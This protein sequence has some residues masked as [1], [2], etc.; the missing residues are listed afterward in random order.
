MIF[1]SD[2]FRHFKPD[3]V[4]DELITRV[5][6]AAIRASS[7]GNTQHWFFIV[8]RDAEVKRQ[9]AALY[10]KTGTSRQAQLVRLLLSVPMI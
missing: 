4:P 8:V 7:G 2:L 6:D 3:P 5:L 9:L 10:R 1:G